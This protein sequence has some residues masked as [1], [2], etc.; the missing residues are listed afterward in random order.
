MPLGDDWG[1]LPSWSFYNPSADTNLE[2][3]GKDEAAATAAAIK[4]WDEMQ[5]AKAPVG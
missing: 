1:A 4:A 5:A 2:V 3:D